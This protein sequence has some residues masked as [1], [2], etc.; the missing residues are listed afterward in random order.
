MT[1]GSFGR[2]GGRD[3]SR[4]LKVESTQK[5]RMKTDPHNTDA[6]AKTSQTRKELPMKR[7]EILSALGMGVGGMAMLGSEQ[8]GAAGATPSP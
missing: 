4:C 8:A 6:G 3:T 7:R 2:H 1:H 5:V